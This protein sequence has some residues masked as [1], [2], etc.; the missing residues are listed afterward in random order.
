M[1]YFSIYIRR[2]QTSDNDNFRK[3]IFNVTKRIGLFF[4]LFLSRYIKIIL[5]SCV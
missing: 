2:G 1:I 3:I 5:H 4:N